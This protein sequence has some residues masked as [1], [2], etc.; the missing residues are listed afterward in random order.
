MINSKIVS[1]CVVLV[2][3]ILF[4]VGAFTNNL[5]AVDNINI[6]ITAS[7]A[8]NN[9]LCVSNLDTSQSSNITGLC[10][11]AFVF[12]LLCVLA[13]L[14]VLFGLF[15]SKKSLV[16]YGSGC[17]LFLMTLVLILCLSIPSVYSDGLSVSNISY[18]LILIIVSFCLMFMKCAYL[19]NMK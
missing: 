18:S 16:H 13:L 12:A 1:L 17:A 5:Y 10:I 19:F 3:I 2:I 11:A 15:I 6:G 7:C 4:N 14:V 9:I 8:D